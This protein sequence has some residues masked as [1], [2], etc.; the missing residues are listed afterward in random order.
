MEIIREGR[1][2]CKRKNRRRREE[3][4]AKEKRWTEAGARKGEWAGASRSSI[5]SVGV[6]YDDPGLPLP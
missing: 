6:G 2:R 4:D 5:E 1:E 3:A